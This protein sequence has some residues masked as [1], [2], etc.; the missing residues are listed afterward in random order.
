MKEK[1]T[2]REEQ[3]ITFF[4]KAQLFSSVTLDCVPQHINYQLIIRSVSVQCSVCQ[5][6]SALIILV[7]RIIKIL[8]EISSWIFLLMIISQKY[9]D[10]SSKSDV[11]Y[12]PSSYVQGQLFLPI[13][14]L[15]SLIFDSVLFFIFLVESSL[16]HLQCSNLYFHDQIMELSENS[17]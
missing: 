4:S 9:V 12:S 8:R 7:Q 10:E 13:E 14:K 16:H 1:I 15:L 2:R 3:A 11:S 5:F 17:R 6:C